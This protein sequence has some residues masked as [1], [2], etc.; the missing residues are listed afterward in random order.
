MNAALVTGALLL[1]FGSVILLGAAALKKM[2]NARR[3]DNVYEDWWR[4]RALERDAAHAWARN[5]DRRVAVR[6]RD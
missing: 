4:L 2:R 3:E 6:A 5:G 1:P